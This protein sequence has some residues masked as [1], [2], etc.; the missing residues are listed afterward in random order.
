MRF[1]RHDLL[2]VAS[3]VWIEAVSGL[4]LPGDASLLVADWRRRGWPVIVRR[5]SAGEKA[6]MVPVALQLP[7]AAGRLRVALSVPAAAVTPRSPVGLRQAAQSAPSRWNETVS[8][9]LDLSADFG[10]P[11][12]Y[13]GLLW[14]HVTGEPVL[15]V[16]SDLDLLWQPAP[17]RRRALLGALACID[18]HS[19]RVDGEIVLEDGGGV[20]WREL[21]A[22]AEGRAADVAVKTMAGVT[23]IPATAI[24]GETV[25]C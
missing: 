11:T 1:A 15:R 17:E 20:S 6:G 7:N 18:E 21:R 13:G 16:N 10:V 8:A 3:E 24:L 22:A 9:L 12:V 14:E 5:R 25:P 19:V 23:L 4:D 2:D